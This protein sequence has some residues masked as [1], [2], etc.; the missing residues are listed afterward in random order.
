MYGMEEVGKE[1]KAALLSML[2]AMM[3]FKPGDQMTAEQIT[4]SEWMKKWALPELKRLKR[5][6]TA[7][8]GTLSR[9]I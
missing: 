1:E 8:E 3:A 5:L 2:K 7:A 6:K 4:E 9:L